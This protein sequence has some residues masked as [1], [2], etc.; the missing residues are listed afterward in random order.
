MLKSLQLINWKTHRDTVL[1]F[2]KGVNVMIGVMGA[3]KSSAMDAIS[4]A[5][6]G[7]FPAL[8]SKRVSIADLISNRPARGDEAEVRLIFDVEGQ[9]YK[10]IRRISGGKASARL[11]K[12]GAYLQT[13]PT[14]VTEEVEVLLKVD[15]DT[16]SRAVYAEQN[17]IDYF[18]ELPKGDRKKQIDHML[19]LDTFVTAEENTTAL[20]NT[21][22]SSIK[23]EEDA[24]SRIDVKRMRDQQQKQRDEMAEKK[25]EQEGLAKSET[26][27]KTKLRAL[28][29]EYEKAKKLLEKKKEVDTELS[30]LNSRISTIRDE[31]SKMPRPDQKPSEIKAMI[32]QLAARE[33]SL[34]GEI[35]GLR[36]SERRMRSRAGEMEA[37]LR[38]VAAKAKEKE[39][40]EKE[41]KEYTL[42]R[43]RMD[44][45]K[46]ENELRD[47]IEKSAAL[48]G[49]AAEAQRWRDE[50]AKHISKCP[51]CETELSPDRKKSLLKGRED[52]LSA[53]HIRAK[54]ME[55]MIV[56]GTERSKILRE[57]HNTVEVA[58]KRLLE[59]KD[60]E[61]TAIKLEKEKQANEKELTK[62]S[63]DIKNKEQEQVKLAKDNMQLSSKMEI[64]ERMHRYND[65]IEKD[66]RL[67]EQ[68]KEEA[69]S[70]KVD[71]KEIYSMQDNLNRHSEIT[72]ELSAK[73]Q[74]SEKYMKA[75]S[76]Q[77]KELELQMSKV[78]DMESAISRR[79]KQADNMNKFK[80]SLLETEAILRSRLIGAINGLMQD[81]WIGIY[82]YKDYSSL[83]LDARADDYALELE[84][85]NTPN[86]EWLQVD[87][88][89]SG[90]ERSIACLTLR[91]AMAMVVVPNL[92]WL[93]LDE[94]T[95]NI[96]Q[97][98]ISKMV[99]VLSTTLPAIVEQVFI[100]TH[101]ES[102]KQIG[103]AKIYQF[104][105]N[106]ELGE[107]TQVAEL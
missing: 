32:E 100:I 93:I 87:T 52:Q 55:L 26:E 22:K 88:I 12:N 31:L 60:I 37:E 90:G 105:R 21:I 14:K 35:R 25:K 47:I 70:I 45:E 3:G 17:R 9:E 97:Q 33:K 29:G 23:F 91:I 51:V 69:K 63:E 106:K 107:P 62:A 7:T 57:K 66:V 41:L 50:L 1:T 78:V 2:R 43:T 20:V 64:A 65:E 96:D 49:E 4:Y 6:F 8:N 103:S 104:D 95:H 5:L 27:A 67:A 86:R 79:K 92:K 36:E 46:A 73:L 89:A 42:D 74:E 80:A 53:L 94:P 16:F 38:Q 71:E 11:E 15:Y 99:D 98:G 101:D 59:Y 48:K 68:K 24:L 34:S 30:K 102:M 19:G 40:I 75:L 56:H 85:L 82:P 13:Q 54:E 83:R 77:A 28:K 58:T 76:E 10:V 39:R 84:A 18:L 44:L 72:A 61:A 81:L